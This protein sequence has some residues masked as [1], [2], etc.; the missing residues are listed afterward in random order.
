MTLQRRVRP[1]PRVIET[2]IT[3]HQ[4]YEWCVVVATSILM[5]RCSCRQKAR[6]R[7]SRRRFAEP[8]RDSTKPVYTIQVHGLHAFSCVSMS[9]PSVTRAAPVFLRPGHD[10]MS[11]FLPE[12]VV[13]EKRFVAV[14]GEV[15]L[16]CWSVI[17]VRHGGHVRRDVFCFLFTRFAA[18][19][20]FSNLFISSID[21]SFVPMSWESRGCDHCD[22]CFGAWRPRS[23]W[24]LLRE[25]H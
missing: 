20:S 19:Q 4:V 11:S 5:V 14:L 25:C 3:Q 18:A 10:L 1:A 22:L 21:V 9:S 24:F 12:K 17:V 2:C 13:S 6:R 23:R 15:H 16:P 8:L 7:R